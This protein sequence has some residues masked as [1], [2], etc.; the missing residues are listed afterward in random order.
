MLSRNLESDF[1][2][3]SMKQGNGQ[4]AKFNNI[5]V[6]MMYFQRNTFWSIYIQDTGLSVDDLTSSR[7]FCD[8]QFNDLIT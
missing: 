4:N 7:R 8:L 5:S 6:I 3:N 1:I 2:V